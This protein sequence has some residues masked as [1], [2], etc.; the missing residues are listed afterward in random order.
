MFEIFLKSD[1]RFPTLED[2]EIFRLNFV[3]GLR[4]HLPFEIT[5][6]TFLEKVDQKYFY[7]Y[8]KRICNCRI[9]TFLKK[10][11]NVSYFE[12]LIYK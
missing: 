5:Q 4:T 1:L 11:Q 9:I 10:I 12:H 7:F 8:Q 2:I 3:S 6:M